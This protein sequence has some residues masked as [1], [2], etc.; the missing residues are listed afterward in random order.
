MLLGYIAG[1]RIQVS[2]HGY[3]PGYQLSWLK[4]IFQL[5]QLAQTQPGLGHC[6]CVCGKAWG[7]GHYWNKGTLGE[8]LVQHNF[9]QCSCLRALHDDIKIDATITEWGFTVL[10]QPTV[11]IECSPGN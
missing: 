10:V 4:G 2:F 3:E 1:G 7:E 5:S 8:S 11:K 6:V 9:W